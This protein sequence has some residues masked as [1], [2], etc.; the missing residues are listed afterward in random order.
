[1][2]LVT[3]FPYTTLF[4]SRAAA[5]LLFGF[6]VARQIAADLRPAL[7]MIAGFENALRCRVEDIGI[8][9]RK[10]E[11]R[12][13]LKTMNNIGRAVSGIIQDRKSTRLNSSHVAI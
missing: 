1:P 13:P 9:R 10:G 4:R 7:P 2:P 8:M 12:H 5:W 11:R 3:L 6:I